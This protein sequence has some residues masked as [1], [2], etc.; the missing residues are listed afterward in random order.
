MKSKWIAGILTTLLLLCGIAAA[1]PVREQVETGRAQTA[2]PMDLWTERISEET[3]RRSITVRMDGSE[4]SMEQPVILNETGAVFFPLSELK[5]AGDCYV[6]RFDDGRIVIEQG[7]DRL[8]ILPD[9]QTVTKNG[10]TLELEESIR[11]IEDE[12]YLPV[13]LLEDGLDYTVQWNVSKRELTL[14]KSAK[15]A[16]LPVR[17]DYR[18]EGR[19]PLVGNQGSDGTC[20]AFASLKAVESTLLPERT[21]DFSKDHMNWNNSSGRAGEGGGSFWMALA[22]LTAWQGPVL[23][24]QDPY[25]DGVSD[26]S[27]SAVMHVQEAQILPEKDLQAIK[28]AVFQTGGVQSSLYLDPGAGNGASPYYR[29]ET[30]AYCYTGTEQSNHDIVIVGWDDAYSKENFAEQPEGDG[31]FLC[32]NSWGTSFGENGYFYVSY[33]DARIGI[34]NIVYS[35]IEEAQSDEVIHQTDLRGFTGQ[36]GYGMDS[37]SFANVYRAGATTELVNACGFYATGADTSYRV[38]VT[39]G[40]DTPE[41]FVMEHPVA[42]GTLPYAGYYT[43]PFTRQVQ[44]ESGESFA[45]IVEITTP[46]ATQPVAVQA[47]TED[48]TRELAN[49]GGEQGYIS[50]RGYRWESAEAVSQARVCLKAYTKQKEE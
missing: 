16:E 13:S 26:A 22:Y 6:G 44:V 23:E 17:Y 42:E 30:A 35:K 21:M 46:G 7:E 12:W 19:A 33:Y 39:K 25:G 9:L 40:A 36:V 47:L 38:F 8:E 3:N 24:E 11:Q 10:T 28:K 45:V 20:W 37:A 5:K 49:S 4:L 43:I 27:L 32:L 48:E 50:Y 15:A 41:Q 29:A 2:H 31:A 34:H 1:I 18:Q 14:K